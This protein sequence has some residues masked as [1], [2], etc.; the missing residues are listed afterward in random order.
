MLTIEDILIASAAIVVVVPA[1]V[2]LA[3][4]AQRDQREQLMHTPWPDTWEKI[5]SRNVEVYNRLP[6]PLQQRLRGFVQVFLAEKNFEGCGGLELTE[7]MRVTV[8]TQACLLLLG[9]EHPSFYRKLRSVLIYPTDF[10]A[11]QR[12]PLGNSGLVIDGPVDLLGQ[13]SEI[14]TVVLAWDSSLHGAADPGDGHNVVLHEFAHQL[15]ME[16]GPADGAPA[17]A[18]PSEAIDWARVMQAEFD[19]LREHIET[20]KRHDID[21]YG[22]TS[23]AEFFAVT[24]EMFFERPDR[25]ARRHPELYQQ[26]QTFYELDPRT[27]T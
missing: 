10:V 19:D 13:A 9:R 1:L 21:A 18:K 17:L 3:R 22:A 27:W 25:L 8:A 20:R 5:T 2:Y 12:Q 6:D 16:A 4:R 15:D 26:L 7:E 11:R 14:G 23:P 24:T